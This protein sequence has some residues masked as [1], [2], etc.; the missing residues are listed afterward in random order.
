V[1]GV[2]IG[3]LGAG[4]FVF[5]PLLIYVLK[6]PTRIA[7]G[8]TLFIA[9]MNTATGFLGKLVTGQILLWETAVVAFG[10]A[11]GALLGEKIHGRLSTRNLRSIYAALVG[12][13][14]VRVWLTVFGFGG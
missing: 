10:A 6:M 1:T 13:I 5:V 9:I 4:N 14:A 7:I 3:V 11:N 12:L 2:A 8:S